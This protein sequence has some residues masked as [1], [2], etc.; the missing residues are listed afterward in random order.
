MGLTPSQVVGPVGSDFHV[1]LT[2]TVELVPSRTSDM[3]V[4][5]FS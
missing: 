1:S 3:R 2:Q 4:L 5:E